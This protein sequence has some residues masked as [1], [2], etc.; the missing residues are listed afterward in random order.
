MSEITWNQ[1]VDVLVVGSGNGGMTAAI[2]AKQMSGNDDVLVI[3]KTEE[4]GGTS[5][6]SGGGVWVPNNRYAQAAGA[7]DSIDDARDYLKSTIPSGAVPEELIESYLENSPK[8]I[9]YL[10]NNTSYVRYISLGQYPD[11]Y[12]NNPGA[13]AG[14]RSMEPEPINKSELGDEYTRIRSTH[15][16]I[17]MMNRIPMTQVEAHEIMTNAPGSKWMLTKLF[18]KYALDIPWRL[19]DKQDR[20]LTC[21]SAGTTRL[22]LSLKEKNIP[23]LFNC[24]LRDLISDESGAVIGVEAEYNGK[25]HFIKVNKGVVLAAGGF[26]QNQA[27]REQYLPQPTSTRWSGG[28]KSNTG[29]ALQ[30]ALKLG[31]K[32]RLMNGAWWCTTVTA[33][34]EVAPRLSI[35]EKSLPGSCVVNKQ[36][37]RISNES[38]NYMAYQLEYFASH[39]ED[40][41]NYPSYMIFDATFRKNYFVG[42]LLKAAMRPDKS[43]PKSYFDEG[44]LA[45]ADDIKELANKTG[46]DEQGLNDTIERLNEYAKTGKDIEHQRGDT[47]YDRYYGDESVT[48]NPCLAAIETGPFYAMKIDPGDFGTHGGLEINTDAQV[49]SESGAPIKGLYATGNCAAAILPTYPGPGATLGPAMTFGYQA[50]KHITQ[51]NDA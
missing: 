36:G 47:E 10:H 13:R 9:D 42:P 38:Q 46:I 49:L 7:Q 34:D 25:S 27:L 43:L 20:R 16:M 8:V 1:E 26:E 5:G 28:V 24:A 32:T 14:H 35:M 40:A 45:I 50:A 44:F 33:P 29:D 23:M 6:V 21:G 31:A 22:Y 30:A 48:P 51:F 4:F 3:E 37:K 11:Y 41:S 12:M 18:L 15:H 2:C 39:S 17:Y 19:K